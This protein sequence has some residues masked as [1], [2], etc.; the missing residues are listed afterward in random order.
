M[1]FNELTANEECDAE[2]D[3]LEDDFTSKPID[4]LWLFASMFAELSIARNVPA[5]QRRVYERMSDLCD[6]AWLAKGEQREALTSVI[7][8][9]LAQLEKTL[10]TQSRAHQRH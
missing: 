8:T 9:A 1:T 10:R 4:E 6:R 5:K 3:E 7:H 2:H